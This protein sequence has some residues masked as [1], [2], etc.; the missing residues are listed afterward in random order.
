[1]N[2]NQ[3]TGPLPAKTVLSTALNSS[4]DPS[5]FKLSM[6]QIA[7]PVGIITTR[8]GDLR[9]GLTATSICSVSM[10]P[11]T[12]LVC[13]NRNASAEKTIAE[14]GAFAINMLTDAQHPVARLFSTP[15][16]CPEDRFA[17]GQWSELATGAPILEGAVATFD[18]V[19]EECISSGSHNL[20]IGRV[21]ATRSQ[22]QDILLYRDGLFR[23]L[24]S[25]N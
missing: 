23:R 5:D 6:R 21:I 4:V 18:C 1:M 3:Q 7:S 22:D 11:P 25:V 24:E 2:A 10:E 19:V 12:M 14:S 16:L 8:H 17:G 20:Y 15:K 9:N 13:V